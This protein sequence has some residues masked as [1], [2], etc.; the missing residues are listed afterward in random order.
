MTMYLLY[1]GSCYYKNKLSSLIEPECNIF[2]IIKI[3][4]IWMNGIRRKIFKKWSN[5]RHKHKIK[6]LIHFH[7]LFLLFIY[8]FVQYKYLTFYYIL[9]NYNAMQKI[10]LV[11]FIM[12]YVEVRVPV[13]N[14][15][16][17]CNYYIYCNNLWLELYYNH[18]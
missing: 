17:C 14:E 10:G 18:H 9:D 3:L 4:V 7:Y 13:W 12:F 8:L 1:L 16:C 5:T 15:T 2:F 11:L 6:R